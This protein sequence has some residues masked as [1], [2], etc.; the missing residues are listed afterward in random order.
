MYVISLVVLLRAMA[1]SGPPCVLSALWVRLLFPFPFTSMAIPLSASVA[2]LHSL[3]NPS[4][5]LRLKYQL[6]AHQNLT[7]N[8]TCAL[9]GV[10]WMFHY[11]IVRRRRERVDG[12]ERKRENR[13][14]LPK[15][16]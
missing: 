3:S 11:V 9:W 14:A 16:G 2:L 6:Q 12:K 5:K 15:Y 13:E 8:S 10:E 1:A 7:E 4:L